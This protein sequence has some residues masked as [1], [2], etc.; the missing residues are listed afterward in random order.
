MPTGA[1]VCTTVSEEMS[2][3]GEGMKGVKSVEAE[4]GW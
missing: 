2:R 1:V 4:K 3:Y